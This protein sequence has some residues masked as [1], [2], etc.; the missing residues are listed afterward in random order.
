MNNEFESLKIKQQI[1]KE[2]EKAIAIVQQ[3]CDSSIASEYV[4]IPK[5][6][7][8]IEGKYVVAI[9]NWFADKMIRTCVFALET[10]EAEERFNKYLE[11]FEVKR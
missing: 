6:V 10:A 3:S 2:T 9:K 7:S 4:W 8:R 11:K 5:S 1:F